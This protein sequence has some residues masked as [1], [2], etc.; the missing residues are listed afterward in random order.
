VERRRALSGNT[1]LSK[2]DFARSILQAPRANQP[3]GILV[4]QNSSPENGAFVPFFGKPACANLTFAKLAA[5]SGAAVIPGFAV[6]NQNSAATCC[7]SILR[8]KSGRC[9]RR[10]GPHSGRRRDGHSRESR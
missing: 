2:R 1:L 5:R 8:S 10:H 3:V 9:R 6:W 4:D 7:A